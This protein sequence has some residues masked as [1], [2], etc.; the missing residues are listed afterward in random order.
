VETVH[1]PGEPLEQLAAPDRALKEA[2]VEA[3]VEIEQEAPEALL[4]APTWS[5]TGIEMAQRFNPLDPL[6]PLR[7]I[8]PSS[9]IDAS[10]KPVSGKPEIGARTG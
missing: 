10:Q 9:P 2:E 3:G 7:R 1:E 4:P 5:F 6:D 8:D